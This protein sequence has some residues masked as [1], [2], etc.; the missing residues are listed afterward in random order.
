MTLSIFW[1]AFLVICVF[2][3][4]K[5]LFKYFPQFWLCYP[6]CCCCCR[7][8]RALCSIYK[9]LLSDIWSENF[10]PFFVLFFNGALVANFGKELF[11]YFFF[12]HCAFGIVSRNLL[13]N[14]RL[15]RDVVEDRTLRVDQTPL[16]QIQ[17]APLSSLRSALEFLL[18]VPYSRSLCYNLVGPTLCHPMDCSPPGSSVHGILQVIILE[19]VAIPFSR[20]SSQ[21]RD[22]IWV[23]CIIY[24]VLHAERFLCSL[25]LYLNFFFVTVL[26]KFILLNLFIFTVFSLWPPSHRPWLMEAVSLEQ[27]LG[28]E[29]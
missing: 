21:P 28:D 7:E 29:S 15:R 27:I 17:P 5:Q 10:L 26:V 3:F 12:C 19:W 6:F 18:E 20:G 13:L 4:N 22:W 9:R 11:I 23:S 16:G 14:P 2:S 1:W 8:G 24:C 25:F